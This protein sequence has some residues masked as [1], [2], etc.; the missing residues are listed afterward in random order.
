MLIDSLLIL[1]HTIYY[2]YWLLRCLGSFTFNRASDKYAHM[3]QLARAF[4]VRIHEVLVLVKMQAK[5]HTSS[6]TIYIYTFIRG[7]GAYD[8]GISIQISFAVLYT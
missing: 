2:Y 3:H 6:F 7:I 1:M 5:S 4:D 8:C